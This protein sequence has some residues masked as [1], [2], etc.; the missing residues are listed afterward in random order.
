M[1]VSI[2]TEGTDWSFTNRPNELKT[3]YKGS[4]ER[5]SN[6]PLSGLKKHLP[7][8]ITASETAVKAAVRP[9]SHQTLDIYLSPLNVTPHLQ[10]LAPHTLT[11]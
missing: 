5:Q 11:L 1:K 2:K 6:T 8:I 3:P 10:I 4:L 7:E 9:E